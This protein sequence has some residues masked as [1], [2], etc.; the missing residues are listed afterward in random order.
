MSLAVGVMN[1]EPLTL[2]NHFLI[3]MPALADF[4]FSHAVV[5]VCAHNEEGAMGIMVNRP[6]MDL[7]LGEVLAQLDIESDKSDLVNRT[8]YLGGPIQTERGFIIHPA[9]ETWQSTLITGAG[10]SVT[11][12]QDILM[13]LVEGQGPQEFLVALGY[14][15][16]GAGQLEEEVANNFWLT[17][18]ADPRI[19]FETAYQNRWE[20]AVTSLGID[21]SNLSSDTGHG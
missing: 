20:Q 10:L 6:L 15:G 11:S 5:Y 2:Q 1:P 9:G 14:A 21:I 19:L 3:A 16:W 17:V 8:V 4:N 12:S 18:P 13:A 7:K